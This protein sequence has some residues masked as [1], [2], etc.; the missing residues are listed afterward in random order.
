M[1][2]RP[3]GRRHRG[4]LCARCFRE[5]PEEGPDP[6][7]GMLPGVEFACCGHGK[8]R[9]YIVFENGTILRFT[10]VSQIERKHQYATGVSVEEIVKWDGT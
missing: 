8:G 3:H 7:L 4:E 6:C 5:L 10:H 1:A 2:F 9:G